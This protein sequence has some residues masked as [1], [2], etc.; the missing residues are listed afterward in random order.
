MKVTLEPYKKVF[1]FS[2]QCILCGNNH[3]CTDLWLYKASNYKW[4][5]KYFYWKD[6][7][8]IEYGYCNRKNC[9]A[10]CGDSMAV[11]AEQVAKITG[12]KLK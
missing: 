4:W 9:D 7:Q 6:I 2:R 10:T 8:S 11:W 12:L 3:Q 1:N 5:A